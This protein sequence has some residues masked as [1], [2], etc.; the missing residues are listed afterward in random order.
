MDKRQDHKDLALSK[1]RLCAQFH[2]ILFECLL[3]IQHSEGAEGKLR[4]A[5]TKKLAHEEG[6]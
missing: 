5:G 3:C 4:E 6:E 2:L 1:V